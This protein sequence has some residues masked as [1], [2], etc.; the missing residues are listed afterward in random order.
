M[1]LINYVKQGIFHCFDLLPP[2][3]ILEGL[4]EG[5]EHVEGSS[6]YKIHVSSQKIEVDSHTFDILMIGE[7]LK[8]RHTR[9]NKA[10]NIDRLIPEQGPV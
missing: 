8:V 4:L 2:Y 6:E 10:I 7:T 3:R 5:K 1:L 9:S